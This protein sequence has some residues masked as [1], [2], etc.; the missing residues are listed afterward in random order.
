[1]KG[2]FFKTN[3]IF[4]LQIMALCR[5]CVYLLSLWVK[6]YCGVTSLPSVIF[7]KM[8]KMYN[9]FYQLKYQHQISASFYFF[10]FY[11]CFVLVAC[12]DRGYKRKGTQALVFLSSRV[13]VR[14]LVV[15]LVSL[16]KALILPLILRL[17]IG[18]IAVSLA[19]CVMQENET[20]ALW[21]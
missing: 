8:L 5:S 4:S 12:H 16:S 17:Q 19:C 14:V 10:I 11:F 9:K 20:R 3:V 2:A 7:R 18:R 6:V 15:T 13:W 21:Y 1:M